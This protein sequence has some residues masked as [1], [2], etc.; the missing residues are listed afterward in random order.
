MVRSYS[1]EAALKLW[2][3]MLSLTSSVPSVPPLRGC[4]L[5]LTYVRGQALGKSKFVDPEVIGARF[6]PHRSGC[7]GTVSTPQCDPPES[8]AVRS[9]ANF[10]VAASEGLSHMLS[11]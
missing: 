6:L 7:R 10:G 2:A 4:I 11:R 5:H 9:D 1:V 8:T 3:A